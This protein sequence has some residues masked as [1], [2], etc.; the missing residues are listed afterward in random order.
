M[1]DAKNNEKQKP[2]GTEVESPVG[3][4]GIVT[5]AKDSEII[6]EI[7]QDYE[8]LTIDEF[9]KRNKDYIDLVYKNTWG[10]GEIDKDLYSSLLLTALN[11]YRKDWSHTTYEQRAKNDAYYNIIDS[12]LYENTLMK[13]DIT[14]KPSCFKAP[15]VKD[16][17]S[18]NSNWYLMELST[19][20]EEHGPQLVCDECIF[21]CNYLRNKKKRMGLSD[22]KY[23]IE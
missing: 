7:G 1:E 9:K 19:C 6:E 2:K 16:Y 10:E 20:S 17:M 13:R 14:E 21:N 15:V 5:E 11:K 3:G 12:L 22:N 23:F 18:R 4:N 8:K